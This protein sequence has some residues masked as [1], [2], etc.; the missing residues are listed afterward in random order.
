MLKI[1]ITG[2]IGTGKSTV[3]K[4]FETLGIPV[5][6]ADDE[7]KKILAH[8]G[9]VHSELRKIFG[10][11]IFI[12]GSPD[13]KKIADI[14]FHDRSKLEQLN[15]LL[16]PAVIRKSEEWFQQLSGVPYAIK[17]AA[18][19]YEVSGEKLLDKVIVISSPENISVQRIMQRDKVPEE[20]IRSRMKNQWPQKLKEDIADFVIRNDDEHLLIPQVMDIH[21]Q[22]LSLGEKAH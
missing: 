19:I 20:E 21:S 7:S 8:D 16:H 9:D 11:E 5:F 1:G 3:C 10:E 14:V 13:R 15:A 6:Y 2:N 4:I 12:E 18:L 17:E 22:L